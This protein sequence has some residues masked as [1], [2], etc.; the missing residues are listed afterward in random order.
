MLKLFKFPV[1]LQHQIGFLLIGLGAA[2]F[3]W[4]KVSDQ[5]D[6]GEMIEKIF[7]LKNVEIGGQYPKVRKVEDDE[8]KGKV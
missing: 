6:T 2:G 4:A 1:E 8:Q 5:L 3:I 7:E